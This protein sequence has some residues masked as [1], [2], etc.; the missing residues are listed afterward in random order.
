VMHPKVRMPL[1]AAI[2]VV[3]AA[4]AIRSGIRGWDFVP[5]LPL[6]A[7]VF[8]MFVVLVVLVALARRAADPDEGDDYLTDEMDTEDEDP[9]QPG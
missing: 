4:Y 6:D 1:W 3:V 2:A 8:G 7:L 9:G 5:D